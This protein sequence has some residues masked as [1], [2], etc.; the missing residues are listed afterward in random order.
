MSAAAH[1]GIPTALFE[2]LKWKLYF[3]TLCSMLLLQEFCT[4][5]L[6]CSISAFRVSISLSFTLR[7]CSNF[8]LSADMTSSGSLD[9]IA[10]FSLSAAFSLS[11]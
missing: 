3:R 11:L 6:N 1:G 4:S 8:I 9:F 10:F 2:L 5:L 7:T